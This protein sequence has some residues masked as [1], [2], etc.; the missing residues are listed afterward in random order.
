M[1]TPR[2]APHVLPGDDTRESMQ[3]HHRIN[4][5]EPSPCYAILGLRRLGASA[6]TTSER[7]GCATA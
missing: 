5:L 1:D 6:S 2:M 3:Y 7:R 4:G